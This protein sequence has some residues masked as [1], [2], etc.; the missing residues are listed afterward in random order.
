M[1]GREEP[2]GERAREGEEGEVGEGAGGEMV[3][4]FVLIC[5]KSATR[6]PSVAFTF[7]LAV[8]TRLTVSAIQKVKFRNK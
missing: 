6:V 4:G 1:D 7:E 8:F 3:L 2:E 5:F